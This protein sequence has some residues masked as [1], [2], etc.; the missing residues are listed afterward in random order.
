MAHFWHWRN[1]NFHFNYF[2]ILIK[3]GRV[4]KQDLQYVLWLSSYSTH[5]TCPLAIGILKRLLEDLK[6]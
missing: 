2:S 4:L 6:G 3:M 5:S 1:D